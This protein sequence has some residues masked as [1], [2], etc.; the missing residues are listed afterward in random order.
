MSA[1][2]SYGLLSVCHTIIANPDAQVGSIGVVISLMN[3]SGA[4]EQAG[5]KRQFVTAGASK[6]SVHC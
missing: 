2:A 1:S 3:N 4:L 5:L 6:S